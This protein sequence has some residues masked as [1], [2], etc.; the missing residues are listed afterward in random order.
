[1]FFFTLANAGVNLRGGGGPLTGCIVGAL[2]VGKVVGITCL[3][4]LFSKLGLAPVNTQIKTPNLLM[5][6]SNAAIGLTVALFVAGEAFP[7]PTLQSEAKFGALLSGLMGVLCFGVSKVGKLLPEAAISK[8]GHKQEQFV[9]HKI[10]AGENALIAHPDRLEKPE[11]LEFQHLRAK[12]NWATLHRKTTQVLP[13]AGLARDAT[14]ELTQESLGGV[15]AFM[16]NKSGHIDLSEETAQR[17]AGFRRANSCRAMEE[18]S[19]GAAG[20]AGA[21]DPAV[22]LTP[23]QVMDLKGGGEGGDGG[24]VLKDGLEVA[25]VES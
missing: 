5:L 4:L 12:K 1:M 11:L 14:G 22:S 25:P 18:A 8:M 3:V 2:V 21:A 19:A 16:A 9:R 15:I 17:T 20:A 24:D 23:V 7:N 13:V 6:S 10:R